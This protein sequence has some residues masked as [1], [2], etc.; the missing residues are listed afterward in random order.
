MI[1]VVIVAPD[2][3]SLIHEGSETRRKFLDNTL[4]QLDQE[5]LRALINYNKILQQRNAALKQ[6]AERQNLTG[7]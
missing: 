2:D 5:Y 4:S 7:H 1:P 3:V 6:F